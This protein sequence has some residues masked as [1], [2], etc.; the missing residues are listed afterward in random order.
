MIVID[1]PTDLN[2]EDDQGRN[3][4]RLPAGKTMVT[5]DVV[6]AGIPGFWSWSIVDEV[7]DGFVFF[8]RVSAAEAAQH[9]EL[10]VLAP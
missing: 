4:A 2:M 3:L 1:L 9:T 10:A 7:A 5:G 6:V 8:H